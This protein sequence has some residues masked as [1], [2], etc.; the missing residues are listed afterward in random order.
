[1]PDLIRYLT[2]TLDRAYEVLGSIGVDQWDLPTPCAEWSVRQLAGHVLVDLDNFRLR[3]EGGTPDWQRA[4]LPVDDHGAERFR[5][6]ADALIAAWQQHPPGPGAP[7][8]GQTISE[9]TIHTWDLARATGQDP[10]IASEPAEFAAAWMG[11]ALKP[12]YRGSASG[13][14]RSAVPDALACERLVAI[15]GRDRAW[16]PGR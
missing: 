16:S 1:M 9:F 2:T 14:E 7:L 10:G 12:E 11:K 4:P 6:E 8:A 5:A 13:A 15:S 3:A